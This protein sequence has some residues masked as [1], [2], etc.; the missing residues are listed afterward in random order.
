MGS[1]F[2]RIRAAVAE[3]RVVIGRH[4][5]YRLDER[6]VAEWQVT[7]GLAHGKL[8]VEWLRNQPNPTVEVEQ[9]LADGTPV[10]AVWAWLRYHEVAKLVTVHFFDGGD[11][12]T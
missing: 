10:K 4:A 6:R 7:S 5:A 8:I 9:L 12:A 2:D 3:G 11:H 1:L